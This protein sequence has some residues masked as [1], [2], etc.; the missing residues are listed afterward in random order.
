MRLVAS[1]VC[2]RVCGAL[3]LSA[4]LHVAALTGI[5]IVGD[6]GGEA[7]PKR[8][9]LTVRL[10]QAPAPTEAARS[11]PAGS[12]GRVA[13]APRYLRPSELTSR[14][15]PI[16]SIEP[17]PLPATA[18]KSGRV[19]ARVLINESG[20]ADRVVIESADPPGVFDDSVVSAFGSARYRPGMLGG[21]AVK[22]QMRVEVTFDEAVPP[23][24]SGSTSKR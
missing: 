2:T 1:A 8:E 16:D 22:S 9:G 17:Q 6:G 23:P 13:L 10:A 21:Q 14:P 24:A 11:S 7:L 18:S 4:G 20:R 5:P 3:A 15:V 12:V 19:I